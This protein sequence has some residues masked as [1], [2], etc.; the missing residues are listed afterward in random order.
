MTRKGTSPLKSFGEV[1][2]MTARFNPRGV[3]VTYGQTNLTW[4]D[5]NGRVNRLA[6]SLA[7]LGVKKGDHAS[8]LFHDC[9]EF[10]VAN[11]ALQKLG[12]VPIPVNFRFVAREI[13]YQFNHSN[14]SILIFDDLY[15]A[16]VTKAIQDAPEISLKVCLARGGRT[17]PAG[18]A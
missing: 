11:Y 13:A 16:E 8:I 12:A 2:A 7:R 3:A 14:S 18:M 1:L 15:L 9:P 5:L 6:N 4:Q 10:I 17:V